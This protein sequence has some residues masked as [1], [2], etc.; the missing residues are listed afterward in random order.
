[1]FIRV[2]MLTPWWPL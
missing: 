1:V 2:I